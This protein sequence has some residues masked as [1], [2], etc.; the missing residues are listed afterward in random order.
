MLIDSKI[1]L[2]LM[3]SYEYS[4]MTSRTQNSDS[5]AVSTFIVSPYERKPVRHILQEKSSRIHL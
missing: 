3:V 4:L 5:K 1:Y 2:I